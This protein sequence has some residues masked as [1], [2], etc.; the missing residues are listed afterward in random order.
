MAEI[1][2][3]IAASHAPFVAMHPQ[4]EQAPTEQGERVI[5][6]FTT[7]RELLEKTAADV[8]VL[9]S[10]DH[11][12]RFF[13][14]NLPAFLVGIGAEAQGP[15]NEW[16]RLPKV[17]VRVHSQL[18]KFLVAEGFKAGIDFARSEELPLDHSECVPLHFLTPRWDVPIVPVVVNTFASP[19]P[20]LQR[21]C[22]VGE[23]VR[24][25]VEKWP[26]KERVAFVGSGGLSHWV[27]IP[28]TGKI[29]EEF[30]RWFLDRLMRRKL[31]EISEAYVDEK[32][33]EEAAGNGG[34]EV[35]DWLSVG[36]AMPAKFKGRVLAYEPIRPWLTGFAVAVWE[37][38]S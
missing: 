5:K 3:G 25:A 37:R 38:K 35:R 30:D 27:G 18:G 33:L 15:V 34:H 26:G 2:A 1:V 10:N 32:K 4:F 36:A 20:T 8:I 17:K 9:F 11:L 14:D 19:M 24:R 7:A 22:Q 21:C 23:F 31:A 16:I 28:G 12:D 6:A 13:F 29:G